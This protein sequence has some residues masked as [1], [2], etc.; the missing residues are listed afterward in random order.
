LTITPFDSE[1]EAIRLANSTSYGL[2]ASVWTGSLARAHRVASRLVAGTVSV[3]TVD[4]LGLSTPFGGFKESGFGR[5]LSLHAL[6][7][8]SAVKTT[9]IQFG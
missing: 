7:N 3:N 2:A 9:W 4:A 5:D 8:Y 1:E 6:D